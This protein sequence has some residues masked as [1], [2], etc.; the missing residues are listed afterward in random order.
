MVSAAFGPAMFENQSK[1]KHVEDAIVAF[2]GRGF[3]SLRLHK[4][5][6]SVGL[7]SR[8]LRPAL[9]TVLFLQTHTHTPTVG[10]Q[11]RTINTNILP[12]IMFI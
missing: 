10:L 11:R 9:Q 8:D 12:Q 1:D 3:E 7:E 5:V 6:W 2:A 4:T